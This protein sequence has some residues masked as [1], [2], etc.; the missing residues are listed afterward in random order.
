[1]ENSVVCTP[2]PS[3]R[4]GQVY[5]QHGLIGV[6]KICRKLVVKGEGRAKDVGRGL[7]KVSFAR[8]IRKPM[9]A[10]AAIPPLVV[11]LF[12][13]TVLIAAAP[14]FAATHPVPLDKNTDA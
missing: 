14:A 13:V 8:Q 6:A 3:G 4:V 5:A 7:R 9:A 12:V 11:L 2:S 1:G 10:T